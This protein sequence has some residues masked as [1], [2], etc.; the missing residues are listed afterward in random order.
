MDFEQ[1][2]TEL[3]DGVLTITLNRPERLNAWTAQMGLELRAAFDRADGD[4]DVRAV[5]VTG[6]GRGFCAGAD[7]ASGGDTF[8]ARRRESVAG[9]M[10]DNGGEL[11]LRIFESTK[12]VI[13]AI[14]G[15]AVGVGATMTLPMDVRLAADDA[16]MGFVF[17]RRGIIPEACSSWFLP[18]VVGISQAMEWVATGR[19]FSAQ[20]A[21]DGR[22]VRSVHPKDELLDAAQALGREIA[23]NTAPVSVALARQLMW[24]MLGADHPMLAHRADSRGMVARGQSADA[25]EGITAFLE[26]RPASFPDRVSEGLPD[27]MPGWEAPDFE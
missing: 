17:A 8:D 6:A 19:V 9:A 16:R 18:R 21:L 20:E 14:N 13:A 23:E 2:T 3:A 26:K 24:R 4:D 7:L 1:I 22:L 5:I 11:T 10:R 27:V 25:V 15:P 12:P